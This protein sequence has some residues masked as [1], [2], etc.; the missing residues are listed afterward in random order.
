MDTSIEL[1]T[2]DILVE[3]GVPFQRQYEVGV[4]KLYKFDFFLPESNT[5]I[6]CD[7]DYWHG[8]GIPAE[9]LDNTQQL[10]AYYDRIKT[11]VA[12]ALGY[13]L[14]RFWESEIKQ[15]DYR[16]KLAAICQK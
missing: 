6:E 1:K 5:L 7:G 3:L 16:T 12:H 14:V 8:K 4:N 2:A 11:E 15:Q 10:V 13:R 9:N